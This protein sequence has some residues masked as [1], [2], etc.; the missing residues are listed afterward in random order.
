[1]FEDRNADGIQG[2]GE[3]GISGVW[4]RLNT[5]SA[6]TA[7]DS[8]QSDAA[9]DYAL[10]LP[11]NVLRD[12]VFELECVPAPGF[13]PEAS[14]VQAAIAGRE[15][16]FGLAAFRRIT[17]SA[18]NVLC[19]GA[20]EVDAPRAL[21]ITGGLQDLG[22]DAE[23]QRIDKSDLGFVRGGGVRCDG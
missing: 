21:E 11:V 22:V 5:V 15:T 1:M 10:A 19:L 16:S 20:R 18:P 6:G 9:G 17:L 7:I 4:V 23:H 14:S 3:P 13:Y 8:V 2:P 12:S